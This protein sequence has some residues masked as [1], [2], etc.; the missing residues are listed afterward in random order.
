MLILLEE[1]RYPVAMM[2]RLHDH[3][4]VKGGVVM[5]QISGDRRRATRDLDLDFVRYPMTDEAIRAFAGT[6]P[7]PVTTGSMRMSTRWC[8]A[9]W[10]SSHRGRKC[11]SETEAGLDLGRIL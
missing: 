7:T 4:T 10:P 2:A 5:Q 6:S 1:G 8:R 9:S 11:L 3:V